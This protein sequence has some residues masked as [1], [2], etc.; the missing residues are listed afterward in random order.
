MEGLEI[1]QDFESDFI[2]EK[3]EHIGSLGAVISVKASG[4]GFASLATIS[5][6]Q[7]RSIFYMV[8]SREG[9]MKREKRCATHVLHRISSE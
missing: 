1:V 4:Y 3:L 5:S 7:V 9:I 2:L 6:I 8:G